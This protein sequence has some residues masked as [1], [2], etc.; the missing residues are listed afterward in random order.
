MG[1]IADISQYQGT[2]DFSK[3][4]S[5]LDLVIIRVQKGSSKVDSKYNDNVAG[6]KKYGI[7]F[8]HYA[9]A[10][11]VSIED[12][13]V[14]AKDFVARA[15]KDAK[16]L[17]VDVEEMTLRNPKDIVKAT[18]AYIDVLKKEFNKVGLYTGHSFYQE[19]EMNKVDNADFLWIPRY[20]K[21]DIGQIHSSKP[22]MKCQLWQ[23]TQC[24]KL[25][26]IKGNVDLNVIH[27]DLS[28]EWFIGEDKQSV[29]SPTM[30]TTGGLSKDMET[31][32]R[33]FL[34]SIEV[35]GELNLNN[36]GN[37]SLTT[38]VNDEKLIIVKKFLDDRKWYYKIK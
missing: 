6:C 3:V 4:K 20:S 13:I 15:D 22:D 19:H 35:N 12:A 26:G 7:P 29:D 25:A 17:V 24:G 16:F 11:F 38:M 2:I 37:P 18:K 8:G 9:F 30:I 32:F 1:K 21:N 5:E 27:G 33:E 14:E 23:Y 10:K 34:K 36:E 28:L 31:E